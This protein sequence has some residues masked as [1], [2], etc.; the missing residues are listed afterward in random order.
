MDQQAVETDVMAMKQNADT[1][2]HAA[3]VAE[4]ARTPLYQEHVDLGARI[5][6]Q[7]V[8]TDHVGQGHDGLEAV[9][10]ERPG[11]RNGAGRPVRPAPGW[12]GQGVRG[13]TGR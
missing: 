8:T 4:P 6:E 3:D 10:T 12:R 2:A 13:V 1:R 5:G 9:G 7:V 11:G